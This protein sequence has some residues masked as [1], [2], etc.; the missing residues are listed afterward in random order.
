MYYRRY[1]RLRNTVPEVVDHAKSH[2]KNP[3]PAEALLWEM[4]RGRKV[5][6][7]K[8]RRQHTVGNFILDFWCPEYR[9]A[10]E[11]DRSIHELP[12]VREHDIERQCWIEAHRVRVIRF[13]NEEVIYQTE[14]VR[15][16][17]AQMLQKDY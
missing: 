8:F 1:P 11:V 6:G 2:R 7:A 16:K 13:R 15:L 9:L 17:I 3:T 10:I 14:Q 5:C 4:L 12:D